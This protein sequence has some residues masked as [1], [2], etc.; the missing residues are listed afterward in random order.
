MTKDIQIILLDKLH[1]DLI[2]EAG[3]DCKRNERAT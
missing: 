2:Y 1:N 3:F